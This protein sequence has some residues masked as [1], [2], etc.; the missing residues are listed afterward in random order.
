MNVTP[1]ERAVEDL[2]RA[3]LR[4][5]FTGE[6]QRFQMRYGIPISAAMGLAD[7]IAKDLGMTAGDLEIPDDH[8]NGWD[9]D[10]WYDKRVGETTY[11]FSGSGY[12]GGLDIYPSDG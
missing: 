8:S 4:S 5:L 2:V 11:T 10:C 3:G 1:E 7:E 9:C 6:T 12:N